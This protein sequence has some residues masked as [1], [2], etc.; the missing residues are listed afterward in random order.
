[1]KKEVKG[2]I[3]MPNIFNYMDYR[4][5]LKDFYTCHKA[6]NPGF[7]YKIM[8]DK[9]GFKSKSFI[10]LVIDG[11]KNLTADSLQ[12]LNKVLKLNDNAFS[13]FDDLVAFNQAK[14]LKMRNYFFE[15]L[16]SY[17]KRNPGRLV[18]QHQYDFYAKWYHNTIRELVTFYRFNEDYNALAKMIHPPISARTARESVQLLLELELIKKQKDGYVQTSPLLSTGDEVKSVA[19]Q[20]FHIQNMVLGAESIDTCPA[21]ERDISCLVLGLSKEGFEMVKAET[22]AFRKRLLHIAQDDRGANRV[23]HYNI[24][25][26]PTSQKVD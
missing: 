3:S 7:S 6:E 19:V 10:K 25:L 5:F 13:Y 11:K 24:Q 23:Y 17:R 8:A 12:K 2:K 14:S 16:F 20:N 18:M 22:Q 1:L 26:F 9:A 4:E 15:R 21:P